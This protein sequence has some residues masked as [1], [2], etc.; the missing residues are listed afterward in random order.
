[1][2]IARLGDAVRSLLESLVAITRELLEPLN[3]LGPN[4]LLWHA[5]KS[6]RDRLVDPRLRLLALLRDPKAHGK[7]RRQVFKALYTEYRELREWIQLT[8]GYHRKPLAELA[9][10]AAWWQADRRFFQEVQ[11]FPDMPG[12]QEVRDQVRSMEAD[13]YPSALPSPASPR[14]PDSG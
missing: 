12:L 4:D 10:Y 2:E 11:R 5:G 3:Q 7:G 6:M 9:T 1:M 8:A 13:G 14:Q